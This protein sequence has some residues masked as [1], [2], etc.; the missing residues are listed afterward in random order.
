MCL[1]LEKNNFVTRVD[2]MFVCRMRRLTCE[3]KNMIM[4]AHLFEE[5]ARC[6][7]KI[8]KDPFAGKLLPILGGIAGESWH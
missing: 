1:S 8:A 3:Y 6:G 4:T 5:C 7:N 2:G